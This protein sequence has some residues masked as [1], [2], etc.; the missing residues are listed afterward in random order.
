LGLSPTATHIAEG[1]VEGEFAG[2]GKGKF[3]CEFECECE[4]RPSLRCY[5]TAL[6]CKAR[7]TTGK[8]AYG[9]CGGPNR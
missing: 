7:L 6:H 9:I 5:C 8:R 2:K 4:I 1:E 3:D